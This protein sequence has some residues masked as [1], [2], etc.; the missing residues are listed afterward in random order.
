MK[1]HRCNDPV[2]V[3]DAK[4]RYPYCPAC[5]RDNADREALEAKRVVRFDRYR[6]A[7]D[8]S[9]YGGAA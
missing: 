6:V 5:R 1:C 3:Y 8:L 9:P 7:K 2:V 4:D